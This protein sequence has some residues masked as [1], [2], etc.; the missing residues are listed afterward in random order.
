MSETNKSFFFAVDTKYGWGNISHFTF[1]SEFGRSWPSSGY[2]E[3]G[4]ITTLFVLSLIGNLVIL[5]FMC[6]SKVSLTITNYFV[7]NL[8]IADIALMMSSP[9]VAYVRITGTWRLGE[10]MCHLLNY[11][12]FVCGIVM[13]WTMTAI[14]IDRYACINLNMPT[15]KRLNYWHVAA[16]CLCIWVV[17]SCSLLPLGLF[18][19]IINIR[20]ETKTIYICS[21]VWP[22]DKISYSM[23]FTIILFIV[24]Y[25]IPVSII[26]VNYFR[27]FRK[28]WASKRAVARSRSDAIRLRNLASLRGRDIKIVKMLVLLVLVFILMGLP[29]FIVSILI[30]R[31]SVY[32]Y[33][34]I[35]SSALLWTV[36]V[37]YANSC[38]NP[39][40]YGCINV[41]I[42]RTFHTCCGRYRAYGWGNI[43][44]FTFFSEF[45]RSRPSSGY[46]EAGII[47]I[48]FVLSLIG[49]FVILAFMC[50]SK[51]SL[52]I[53]NYFVC[54]LAVADIAFMMSSPFVAYVRITGTWRLGEGMCHFLNYWMF[55]CGIV[56]IWTMTAISIDRYACI[57][58]NMPTRKRLNP[59]HVGLICLCIWV[60]TSCLFLPL[61]L[62]FNIID[63][64]LET[65]TIYICSL[66]WPKHKFRY[67]VLF[68][69]VLFLVGFLL[70]ISIITVN[71]IRIFR[72][73]WASKRAVANSTNDAICHRRLDIRSRRDLKIVKTLVLLVL[74]FIFMWLPLFIVSILI[75][76]DSS[77]FYNNISSSALL[78]TIVFAYSNS[79]VNPFMYG[80]INV[81]IHRT[82]R[83]CCGQYR[84]VRDH[85]AVHTRIE[86]FKEEPG[87]GMSINL[88]NSTHM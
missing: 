48:V 82:F 52:T 63:I 54:N 20:Y 31:D 9:F 17:T 33:N 83:T 67:S 5:L 7:C 87:H 37:A 77:Y 4:I 73:F 35:S 13:I 38:F 2:V 41:E 28:F 80:F 19:N 8:A 75:E 71:Y 64:R 85:S 66:V 61:G 60:V 84:T 72:K 11:W 47:T 30:E 18:F 43:S 25:L 86:S 53:T 74:V 79:L 29:L 14:S 65:E 3:A 1:F 6:R 10:G 68:T 27:I 44:V 56:I 50:K 39:F 51:V 70:P 42:C 55:V 76:R 36:N 21:L 57:N 34:S 22:K 49:N 15:R 88:N 24:G 78:W 46:V 26:T 59:W 69:V 62:F 40:M 16:I 81:E 12:M 23:L 58:L 45:N 32:L